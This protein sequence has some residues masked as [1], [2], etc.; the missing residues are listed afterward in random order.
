MELRKEEKGR[1]TLL[2]ELESFGDITLIRCEQEASLECGTTRAD[3]VRGELVS[4]LDSPTENAVNFGPAESI[5][6]RAGV[7]LARV[8]CE[9]TALLRCLI[10]EEVVAEI[11]VSLRIVS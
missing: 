11:V 2:D 5:Q 8:G 6:V 4:K 3:F 1:R 7:G 10:S 9:G